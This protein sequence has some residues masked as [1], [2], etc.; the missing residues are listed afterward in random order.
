M[1]QRAL[2]V[3][4]LG[5]ALGATAC[6]RPGAVVDRVGTAY[7]QVHD[8]T[9][10]VELTLHSK[11]GVEQLTLGQR[12]RRPQ[13]YRVEVL[14]PPSM[15]GQLTVFDGRTTW[16]YSPADNEV[17]MLRG[18][19]I[20]VEE[21]DQIALLS[22]LVRRIAD[23][24]KLRSLGRQ[25][26]AGIICDVI[27]LTG[28]RAAGP[29]ARQVVFLERRHGLPVR[30]EAFDRGGKAL[31]GIAFYDFVIN[32]GLTEADFAF[33]PPPG[34]VLV[35][36][37]LA[38]RVASLEEAHR[39]APFNLVVPTELPQ[40]FTLRSV[41]TLGEGKELAVLLEYSNGTASI[42]LT[43]S[44]PREAPLL[45]GLPTVGIAGV[46]AQVMAAGHLTLLYWSRGGVEFLL[47]G[48]ASQADL[49]KV[50]N[51]LR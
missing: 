22:G 42:T 45:S 46:T 47:A 26:W 49:V 50:A 1:S 21:E 24:A 7:A 27:E 3:L 29:V 9:A 8:Y 18:G 40:G 33:T 5:V 6:A 17:H 41:A 15:K 14:A 19:G 28:L 25:R 36:S 11:D 43:E 10:T 2:L 51:S 13:F 12:F 37:A 35:P 4:C 30:L 39:A 34:A 20:F 44:L 32:R 16:F 48:E 31:L 38:E 23:E